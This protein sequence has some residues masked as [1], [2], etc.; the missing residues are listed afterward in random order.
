M[1]QLSVTVVKLPPMVSYAIIFTHGF[2]GIFEDIIQEGESLAWANLKVFDESHETIAI[3]GRTLGTTDDLL[4]LGNGQLEVACDKIALDA[5]QFGN[6][7]K[8]EFQT[9]I[10]G[11]DLSLFLGVLDRLKST[12]VGI[13]RTLPIL[14]LPPFVG[15]GSQ[16]MAG[17]GEALQIDD[18]GRTLLG[19][20]GID[21]EVLVQMNAGTASILVGGLP[22]LKL[23][24]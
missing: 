21:L 3:C 12:A 14:L 1:V 8:H 20:V 13:R 9:V 24:L 16:E 19:K 6:V 18:G 10:L 11:D 22:V 15:L 17:V 2:T 4:Q 5:G 23:T 7:L